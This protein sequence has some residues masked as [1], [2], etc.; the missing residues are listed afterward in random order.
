M[1][2]MAVFLMGKETPTV[3]SADYTLLEM[4][5]LWCSSYSKDYNLLKFNMCCQLLFLNIR[6]KR[7]SLVYIY[8][9]AVAE[10]L[11]TANIPKQTSDKETSFSSY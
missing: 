6:K 11:E 10:T 4:M 7:F 3:R 8:I 2:K 9:V 1:K 5:N